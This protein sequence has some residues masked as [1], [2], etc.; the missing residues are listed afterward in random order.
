MLMSK[1][2]QQPSFK[3]NLL[4]H[5]WRT[6]FCP[7]FV[8]W[9]PFNQTGALVPHWSCLTMWSGISPPAKLVKRYHP[10]G[11]SRS[12]KAISPLFHEHFSLRRGLLI[13]V[14]VVL[15]QQLFARWNLGDWGNKKT[16]IK[17]PSF[18]SESVVCSLRKVVLCLSRHEL[19]GLKCIVRV[20]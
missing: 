9:R 10:N 16:R 20:S 6:T 12:H 7:F 8:G 15:L 14:Y 18:S 5:A 17:D 4:T 13:S 2:S 3:S 19:H 1:N 11:K